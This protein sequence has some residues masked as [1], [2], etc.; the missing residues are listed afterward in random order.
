MTWLAFRTCILNTKAK[1]WKA[2]KD[3]PPQREILC[4]NGYAPRSLVCIK[5]KPGCLGSVI[6]LWRLQVA[7]HHVG[8]CNCLHLEKIVLDGQAVKCTVQPVQYLYHLQQHFLANN[9]A[10]QNPLSGEALSAGMLH[11]TW[12]VGEAGVRE[13]VPMLG[14]QAAAL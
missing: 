2:Q 1:P 7:H 11:Q 4:R 3:S 14:L 5:G 13:G 12:L 8:A 10:G 6:G 9:R